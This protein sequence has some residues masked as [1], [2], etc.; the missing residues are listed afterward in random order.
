MTGFATAQDWGKWLRPVAAAVRN[1]PTDAD[2][3]GRC[4]ALAF[5]CRVAPSDLTD[6]RARDLCRKAEFWPSVA[7]IEA[8]FAEAWKDRARSAAIG[9]PPVPQLRSPQQPS[10]RTPEEV[11]AVRAK[12][13]AFYAEMNGRSAV[14]RADTAKPSPLHPHDLLAAYDAAG[15]PAARFRADQIRK[16]LE[17]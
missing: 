16:A 6:S 8:I 11:E 2:F 10:E 5:T 3:R 13:A 17:A 15:T 7:E 9:G 1:P 14:V 12:A 4:M